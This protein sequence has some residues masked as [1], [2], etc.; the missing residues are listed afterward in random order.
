MKIR[1]KIDARCN[2]GM[3]FLIDFSSIWIRLGGQVGAKIG[4]QEGPKIDPENDRKK[5]TFL[6]VFGGGERT[7]ALRPRA[8]AGTP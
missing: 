3:P 1:L 5:E 2:I 4:P 8:R 6:K 7:D